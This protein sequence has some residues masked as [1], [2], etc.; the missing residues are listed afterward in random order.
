MNKTL[1]R[2][3]VTVLSLAIVCGAVWGGL[4]IYKSAQKKPV[5]VYAVRDFAMTEYWGDSGQSYGMVTT[6]KLQDVYISDT[7]TIKEIFVEEGQ[8]VKVGDEILSYDTTLS[9]IDLEKAS[10]ELQ[11]LQLQKETAEKELQEIINMRPHSSVLITPDSTGVEYHPQTTPQRLSGSGTEDDPFYYLWGENDVFNFSMLS[12]MFPMPPEEPADPIEPTDPEEP[13]DPTEP[14]D[15]AEPPDS[16][17]QGD[18]E[19]LTAPTDEDSAGE[20][21]SDDGVGGEA[22]TPEM[23]EEPAVN[24]NESYVV[25]LVRQNNALNAPIES[26]WGLHLDKS[27]G[28]IAFQVFTPVLPEDIQSFETEPEPYYEEYGSEYTAAELAK[29]RNDKELEIKDLEVSIKLAQ[30]NYDKLEQE[31]NDGIVRS[32]IDGTVKLV[33]NPEEAYQNSKPVV[34]ISGGGGYYI[35]VTLNELELEAVS[36][37]Q[38]V[39]V[40]SW[41]TGVSCEGEIVEISQYPVESGGYSSD[42]LT[43]NVSSYPF[44]IFVDESAELVANDYVDVTYQK[45]VESGD[46]L[47]LENQ[48]IRNDGG[49]SYVYIRNEDG[50]LEKRTVQTGRGLW[51][52]YTQIVS[53]LTVDDYVAFPYGKDVENGAKTVEGTF[54][55]LYNY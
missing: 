19:A 35:D 16:D 15:P 2:V 51:G 47:Y 1:K 36:V 43:L 39:Q 13:T 24:Y 20:V 22:E 17:T 34:Q 42:D 54:E 55:D 44:R 5:Y 28:D 29:M 3:L 31:I 49:K 11:K 26:Y 10:I 32:T 14:E 12:G 33:S 30:V 9:D 23:P 45:M 6:D 40:T 37:G 50:L 7:Q 21:E 4:L 25:F 8:H 38:T 18:L 46:S 41:N 48:F 52:S 53:G 27:S